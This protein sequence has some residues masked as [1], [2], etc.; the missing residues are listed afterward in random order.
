M[1][2]VHSADAQDTVARNTRAGAVHKR[3]ARGTKVVGYDIARGDGM[4]LKEKR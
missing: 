4:R 1:K 3:A 2:I